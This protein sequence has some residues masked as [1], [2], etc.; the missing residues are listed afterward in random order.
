MREESVGALTM[1]GSRF[2]VPYS[3]ED[4]NVEDREGM[5]IHHV[6][7]SA[8]RSHNGLEIRQE[9]WNFEYYHGIVLWDHQDS[10]PAIAKN[11]DLS[12]RGDP[13]R[14]HAVTKFAPTDFGRELF[15]LYEGGFMTD[16]SVG[17]MIDRSEPVKEGE[18]IVALR[19]LSQHLLE[20]SATP[21]GANPEAVN[22]ALSKGLIRTETA[23]LFMLDPRL[24]TTQN[25]DASE[26]GRLPDSLAQAAALLDE[27]NLRLGLL[28]AGIS[29]R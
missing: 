13:L 1:R 20:Y 19:S 23:A 28:R 17:I 14:L 4:I 22:S 26:D 2:C 25:R 6:I 24:Q 15:S 11:M 16:W 27:Q 12:A 3:T 5:V 10:A 7:S 9:G 18:K 21:I 29:K 8:R